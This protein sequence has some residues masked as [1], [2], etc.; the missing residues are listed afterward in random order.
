MVR[1]DSG[2]IYFD[3]LP[4]NNEV[5][6]RDKIGYMP[7]VGRYPDNMK[8]RQVFEMIKNIRNA[9]ERAIDNDLFE[10]FEMA[11]ISDKTMQT[12]SG[13]TRQKVSATLAFMFNPGVLILDEPT[14]GLDPVASEI[15]KTKIVEEKK[16]GKLILI[17]SH[18]LSDLDDLTTD[19]MY[20]QEGKVLFYDS[21]VNIQEYTKE[22]RLGRAVAHLMTQGYKKESQ[23]KQ[24]KHSL[25]TW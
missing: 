22:N 7:Q 17:T 25:A 19:I 13:G 12:L 9:D 5:N 2:T 10:A 24:N 8:I 20:L 1:P 21:L 18:V 16:R 4:I 6:Y 23:E 14:A 3:G 15:L 11:K